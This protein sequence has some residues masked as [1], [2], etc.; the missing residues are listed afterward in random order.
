MKRQSYSAAAI[1][2]ELSSLRILQQPPT[3]NRE[4]ADRRQLPTNSGVGLNQPRKHHPETAKT[5]LP[6]EEFEST[7]KDV[8]RFTKKKKTEDGLKKAP[9]ICGMDQDTMLKRREPVPVISTQQ[10]NL[11][12]ESKLS[13]G[14]LPNT[15]CFIRRW[16]HQL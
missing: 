1:R 11:S 5:K 3:K 10:D 7:Q 8:G 6:N 12:G 4:W 16:R 9:T 14:S 13:T 15:T 2:Q